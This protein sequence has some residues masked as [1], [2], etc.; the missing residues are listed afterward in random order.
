MW[1]YYSVL[2]VNQAGFYFPP[3]HGLIAGN[4]DGYSSDCLYDGSVNPRP[5][6]YMLLLNFPSIHLHSTFIIAFR[7]VIIQA[8][9]SLDHGLIEACDRAPI[10]MAG[11]SL[12]AGIPCSLI[13][14][15]TQIIVLLS[16]KSWFLVMNVQ[17]KLVLSNK[18]DIGQK[19]NCWYNLNDQCNNS[20][21]QCSAELTY[22]IERGIVHDGWGHSYS[23][24]TYLSFIQKMIKLTYI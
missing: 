11:R 6:R 15:F 17:V 16:E 10:P 22:T 19:K 13:K 3:K 5:L 23:I 18:D 12:H 20:S 24:L 8:A 2:V 7:P 4:H 9:R 1:V 14:T 21:I